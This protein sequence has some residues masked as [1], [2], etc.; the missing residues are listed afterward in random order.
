LGSYLEEDAEILFSLGLT[1]SQ[2]RVYL[3]L[4]RLGG[5]DGKAIWNNCKIARQEIYRILA[6]LQ[7][8]GIVEKVL[9]TPT[10]FRAIPIKDCLS[11]LLKHKDDEYKEAEKKAKELL[12]R[13]EAQPGEMTAEKYQLSLTAG[14][15]SSIRKFMNARDNAKENIDGIYYWKGFVNMITDG[16]EEYK[17]ILSKGTEIRFIIYRPQVVK[18]VSRTILSLK[19]K[20]SLSIRYTPNAPPVTITIFDKKLTLISFEPTPDPAETSLFWSNNP[21]FTVMFQDYFE[22]VWR[23]STK[24][25][26]FET[27]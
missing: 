8:R 26:Q 19:K 24:T 15:E 3:T 18:T 25:A 20:G 11:T 1:R 14:K 27:A 2:A 12:C 7:K 4:I 17:K 9:T 13:F 16:F 23:N 22:E 21:H 6:E 5:A 10:E